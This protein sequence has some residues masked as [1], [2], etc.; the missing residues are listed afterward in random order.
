MVS[1]LLVLLAAL[2]IADRLP[3]F[4]NRHNLPK[5]ERIW[6]TVIVYVLLGLAFFAVDGAGNIGAYFNHHDIIDA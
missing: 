1:T 3:A 2:L 5:S 6:L 4:Y